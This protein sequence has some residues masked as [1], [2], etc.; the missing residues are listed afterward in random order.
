MR[1]SARNY[2]LGLKKRAE[3]IGSSGVMKIPWIWIR[4]RSDPTGPSHGSLFTQ[5]ADLPPSFRTA[6]SSFTPSFDAALPSSHSG[7]K[8]RMLPCPLPAPH[9]PTLFLNVLSILMLRFPCTSALPASPPSVHCLNPYHS[10]NPS[11]RNALSRVFSS[12]TSGLV[13]YQYIFLL[14]AYT[15]YICPALY[16]VLLLYHPFSCNIKPR[17]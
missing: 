3:I 9:A 11:L 14:I 15:I 2:I 8:H 1:S 7:T 5:T 12:C 10:W 6:H 13:F 4:S 17:V 16:T